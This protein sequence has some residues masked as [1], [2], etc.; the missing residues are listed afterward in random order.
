MD[1]PLLREFKGPD[2]DPFL[3][4]PSLTPPEL[5]LVMSL[6]SDGFNPFRNTTR[7]AF[8]TCTAIY[9]VL[10]SL[11]EH[12]R[13]QPKYLYLVTVLPGK[14]QGNINHSLGWLVDQ[15]LPFWNEGVYYMRTARHF[16]GRKVFAVLI[17]VVCDTEAAHEIS[18]FASHSHTYF[19]RRCLLK[20]EN[21]DNLNPE[22]WP[23]CNPQRHKELALQWKDASEEVQKFIYKE[24]GLHWTELL[25]LPYLDPIMF[26]IFDKLHFSELGLKE[27]HFRDFFMVDETRNGGEGIGFKDDSGHR[28]LRPSNSSLRVAWTTIRENKQSLSQELK[29]LSYDFLWYLCFALGLRTSITVLPSYISQ[30]REKWGTRA[31]GT[32]G[33]DEWN[34][35]STIH[36]VVSLIWI[37]GYE[38]DENSRRFQLLLNY[39][40][41]VHAL[42]AFSLCET[43]PSLQNYYLARM[44]KYLHG[45]LVLYPDVSLKPNHHYAVHAADDLRLFGPPH[46]RSTPVFE[47]MNHTLQQI[48]SN[49]H[50]GKLYSFFPLIKL[51]L[52]F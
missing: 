20:L 44:L 13:Y 40:D 6:G 24:H 22:T 8:I 29:K 46:A 49:N 41:M 15:L 45:L 10:L 38:Y 31:G 30:V 1:S 3:Q 28:R 19:C 34:T 52:F 43:S 9:M 14:P 17:P 33:G 35:L 39:L 7:G 16:L 11:P 36:L 32:L 4:E 48:P 21:I 5:R 23:Q 37:W 18:G 51:T 50:L 26:T 12:L 47:R 2:G 42:H 25:R 27:S